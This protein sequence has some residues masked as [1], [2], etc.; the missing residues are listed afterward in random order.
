MADGKVI[1]TRMPPEIAEAIQRRA[2]KERRSFASML[3]VLVEDRLRELGELP[4]PA[5]V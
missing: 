3:T 2:E 4:E 1:Y 5:Q